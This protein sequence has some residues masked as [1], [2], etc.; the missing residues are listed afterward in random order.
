MAFFGE[1]LE[2]APPSRL[3]WSNDE[4]GDASITTVTF[5]ERDG[6]T[7]LVM[8]ELHPS[9]EALDEAFGGMEGATPEQFRQ[10]DELLVAL[11]DD[12]GRTGPAIPR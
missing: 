12:G 3:V 7:R 5:E 8:R 6:G 1:Y 10:L 4:G 9:K 11:R 2:V